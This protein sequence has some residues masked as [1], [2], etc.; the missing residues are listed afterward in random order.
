MSASLSSQ[1]IQIA[2][3]LITITQQ[4]AGL[5]TSIDQLSAQ[6]TSLTLG[7]PLAAMATTPVNADGTLGTVDGSPNVNNPIDPRV[8][9]QAGL[10]R[11]VKAT[12]I[13]SALTMLQAVSTLLAGSAVTTQAQSPQ[14]LAKFVGG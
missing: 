8:P 2:N 14:I 9:A 6:Y 12:D 7:T 3:G 10:T 13:G 11:A 5:K 4:L 1:A